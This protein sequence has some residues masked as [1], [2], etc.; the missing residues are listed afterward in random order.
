MFATTATANTTTNVF[1]F[2]KPVSV[3]GLSPQMQ[4]FGG[5]STFVALPASETTAQKALND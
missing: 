4:N 5:F 3:S 1:G 2:L